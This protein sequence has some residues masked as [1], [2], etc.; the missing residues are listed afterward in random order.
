MFGTKDALLPTLSL[1]LG[2]SNIGQAGQLNSIP[3]LETTPTGAVVSV[4]HNPATVNQFFLGGYGTALDQVFT[5][6]FP[7]YNAS[8]TL[9]VPIRNRS[10]RPI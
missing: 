10:A 3:Q 8:I 5:R 9:T 4:P 1:S 2:A 7:N 6:K